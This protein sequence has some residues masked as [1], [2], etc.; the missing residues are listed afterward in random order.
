VPGDDTQV[1]WVWFDALAHYLSA[2]GYAASDPSRFDAY[3]SGGRERV[4]VIGKG[5]VRFH[6]VF[7]PAFLASAGLPWPTDLLVHGY[8]TLGGE[9][10]SKSGRTVDPL[11]LVARYGADAV[12]YYLLRHV[13]TDRDG[14]F[15]PERFAEAHDAE[16]ANGLGN[17]ASR[18]LGATERVTGEV[19]P[20]PAAERAVDE[21]LRFKALALSAS[22]DGAVSRFALDEGLSAIFGIVDETNR[23]LTRE[24]PWTL[25]AAGHADRARTVLRTALEALS[26]IAAEI[27]PFLPTVSAALHAR[28]GTPGLESRSGWNVLPTGARLGRGTP[29]FP[30]VKEASRP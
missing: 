21:E 27:G 20:A 13:R 23:Y 8:V 17:L 14:D 3:W 29:L 1:I 25:A 30:R 28:L 7:W 12:R 9:K 18:L 19:V 26:V 24:A 4:H 2:L 10:I 11:D 15:C 6:A 22:V 5:I 16:L